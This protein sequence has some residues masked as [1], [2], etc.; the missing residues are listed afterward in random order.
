MTLVA[1]MWQT[2]ASDATA[3]GNTGS[4][5][6]AGCCDNHMAAT[7][8]LP[9]LPL[10][11]LLWSREPSEVASPAGLRV[12]AGISR[13]L[14]WIWM[15]S[16]ICLQTFSVFLL[17]GAHIRRSQPLKWVKKRDSKYVFVFVVCSSSPVS[18]S[19]FQQGK[20]D[21]S[22][23]E[24]PSDGQMAAVPNEQRIKGLLRVAAGGNM[25]KEPCSFR[26][27]QSLTVNCSASFRRD[28]QCRLFTA[29]FSTNLCF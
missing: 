26:F 1:T 16:Q 29:D 4:R 27:C 14:F 20:P 11:G 28:D 9:S 18:R 19:T 12:S 17:F 10:G 8:W 21:L 6:F 5:T 13:D 15:N 22:P 25:W 23:A 24:A 2:L 3:A 7:N